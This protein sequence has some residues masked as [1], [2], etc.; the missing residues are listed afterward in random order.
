MKKLKKLKTFAIAFALSAASAGASVL[1]LI[2]EF[3]NNN[4]SQ[5]WE[6][7]S[8]GI[9]LNSPGKADG[10]AAYGLG[11]G[12]AISYWI[13]PSVGAK[14]S[15]DWCDSSWTFASLGM[16]ARGTVRLA[17]SVA[18]SPFAEAGPGWNVKGPERSVVAVAG[19]GATL[20]IKGAPFDIFG[21]YQYVTTS[22]RE[23]ERI[24]F[25]LKLKF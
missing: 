3:I 20:S 10:V 16:T 12:A 2:E 24:L 1:D 13:N 23:Q 4:P 21:A 22:P 17:D 11:G 8:Y 19:A 7:W 5:K 18:L 6:V 14:L 25:G 15:A 9:K